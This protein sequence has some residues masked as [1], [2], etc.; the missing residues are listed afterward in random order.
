MFEWPFSVAQASP[1]STFHSLIVFEL[2]A[3]RY[4]PSGEKA[5]RSGRGVR[6]TLELDLPRLP[7]VGQ[8]P[9][10]GPGPSSPPRGIGRRGRRPRS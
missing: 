7:R 2:D 6:L 9:Q 1:V 10:P 3:A 4:G 5:H 8:V